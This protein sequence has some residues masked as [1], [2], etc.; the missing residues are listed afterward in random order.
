VTVGAAKVELEA[1][2]LVGHQVRVAIR[3][4]ALG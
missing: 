2:T 1:V 3:G 4:L